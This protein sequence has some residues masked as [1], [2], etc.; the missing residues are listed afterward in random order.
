MCTSIQ[1][2]TKVDNNVHHYTTIYTSTQ[3]YTPVHNNIHQYTTIYTSKQQYTPAHNN[4]HQYTA[5]YTRYTPLTPVHNNIHQHTTIYTSTQ[6][7]TPVHT[8]TQSKNWRCKPSQQ[9]MS[10]MFAAGWE[11][12]TTTV[13][14]WMNIRGMTQ[15]GTWT[16]SPEDQSL[17][18][19]GHLT[20]CV[21]ERNNI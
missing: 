2:Y 8:L 4:V 3:Q 19:L 14:V 1:Q 20:N 11:H 7:Y 9:E 18:R 13:T 6:Q 5:I 15:P 16:R 21:I 10:V 12:L 17:S